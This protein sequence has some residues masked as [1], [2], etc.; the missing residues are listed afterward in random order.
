[1]KEKIGGSPFL[2]AFAGVIAGAAL[3]LAFVMRGAVP[4][5]AQDQQ[6]VGAEPGCWVASAGIGEKN[7]YQE[8]SAIAAISD[9]DVW[10]AGYHAVT[11][12]TSYDPLTLLVHW[13]GK[14]WSQV[15]SPSPG[16]RINVLTGVAAVSSDDVWAVGSYALTGTQSKTL[17][18]H[19]D[20]KSWIQIASPDPGV[21]SYLASVAAVSAT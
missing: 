5:A 12:A 1:M 6:T 20:G 13:D 14:S 10:A 19:W 21:A 4:V 7:D 8:L 2:M 16:T 18:L 11:S 17:V 3:L 9:Q 15:A